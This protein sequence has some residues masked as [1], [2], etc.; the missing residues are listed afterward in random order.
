MKAIMYFLRSF[1]SPGQDSK[2]EGA[3]R[4]PCV[5]SLVVD[6]AVVHPTNEWDKPA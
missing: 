4:S 5:S 6:K 3:R 2:D 1:P